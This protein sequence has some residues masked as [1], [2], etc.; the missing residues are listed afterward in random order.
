[1]AQ[2]KIGVSIKKDIYNRVGNLLVPANTKLKEEDINKLVNHRVDLREIEFWI[3][4]DHEAVSDPVNQLIEDASIQVK[5]IF[6]AIRYG[7]S[8]PLMQIKKSLVP[9]IRK[10]AESAN[11]FR[12]LSGLRS[13]DDYTY[14][15]NIGVGVLATIIGKWMNL[16]ENELSMLILGATLHD[17]GKMKVSNEILHKPGKL[18]DTEYQ[19]MKRHTIDGYK[20]LKST[21]GT[22]HRVALIALQH[23][24]REDGSGYPFGLKGDRLDDLTQIVSIADVFHAMTTQRSYHAAS[25]FFSVIKQM[26]SDVL[27]KFN[28]KIF[29]V[30]M[31]RMMESMVGNEA[32]LTDGRRG[33]IVMA[34]R[35]DPIRPLMK[36]DSYFI[37]LSKEHSV[38]LQEI[39]G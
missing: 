1:M 18:T 37:D 28:A 22:P 5:E 36:V 24:E 9:G 3:Q 20:L 7:H 10:A 30:F 38:N 32:L 15:H 33:T 21:E 35:F 29:F 8:I 25:S 2:I 23:H 14:K 4:K 17:V 19:L 39:L 26:H 12:L 16:D 6:D 13:K 11:L 31:N 34:N 27:G